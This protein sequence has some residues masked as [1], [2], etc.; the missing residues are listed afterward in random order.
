MESTGNPNRLMDKVKPAVEQSWRFLK[1]TFSDKKNIIRFVFAAIAVIIT[2]QLMPGLTI[3]SFGV[4]F[5][6]VLVMIALLIAARPALAYVKL[7][8]N[9]V[10]FGI[11]IWL[12]YFILLMF[13][14]WIL[15]YFETLTVW[16]VL[17]YCLIQAV[18]NC[19][20]ENLLQE[21]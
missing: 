15:W 19:I 9:L 21:E 5:L 7:P 18:F 17:L 14:D 3:A 4:A 12:A 11:F 16:W 1:K 13:L 6:L 20:I 10:Y 8:F 2:S